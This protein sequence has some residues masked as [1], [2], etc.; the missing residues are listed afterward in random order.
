M[1]DWLLCRNCENEVTVICDLFWMFYALAAACLRLIQRGESYR[2]FEIYIMLSGYDFV[3]NSKWFPDV[4]GLQIEKVAQKLHYKELE[5]AQ[6]SPVSFT[7][8]STTERLCANL[9]I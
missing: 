2:A 1:K 4:F 9:E 8:L 6:N 7:S 3:A 5:D